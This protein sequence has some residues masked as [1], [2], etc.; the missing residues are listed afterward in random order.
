MKAHLATEN[1]LKCSGLT[2][3]ILR[4][5]VYAESWQRY[6]GDLSEG[7]IELPADGP[8]AWVSRDDLAA[9][10]ARL[11]ANGSS[12]GQTL[13][14]T[15]SAALNVAAVVEIA[16]RILE[17]PMV[18][19]IVSLDDFIVD[20]IA[21]GRSEITA[22]QWATTY[23]AMERGEFARVDSFLQRLLGRQLRSFEE[24]F[25][26]MLARAAVKQTST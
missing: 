19:E 26:P 10:I 21:A 20:R 24:V 13:T 11:L 2:Y 7:V 1:Y 23:F 18:R 6:T 22:R 14:L 16:S 12:K 25:T 15:G 8:I 4:N 9:G 17:V 5:G 3:T